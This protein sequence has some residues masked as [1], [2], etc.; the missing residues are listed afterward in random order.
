[1]SSASSGTDGMSHTKQCEL[2]QY[3]QLS[4]TQCSWGLAPCQGRH[5]MQEELYH[6][7]GMS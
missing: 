4:S 3:F 7:Y 5:V 1:M 6:S 2:C